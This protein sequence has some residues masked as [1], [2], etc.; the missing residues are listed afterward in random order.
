VL[1]ELKFKNYP[2]A[3]LIFNLIGSGNSPPYPF[4]I[5]PC[6]NCSFANRHRNYS[7]NAG[8]I[9]SDAQGTDMESFSFI[10]AVSD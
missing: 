10:S 7:R 5:A 1:T 9:A 8:R 4:E 2:N 6:V 3:L